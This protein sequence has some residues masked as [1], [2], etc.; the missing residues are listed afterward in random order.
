MINISST[1]L[2]LTFFLS[3]H[4]QQYPVMFKSRAYISPKYLKR[5]YICINNRMQYMTVYLC[6]ARIWTIGRG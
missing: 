5:A 3:R 6:C 4:F 1:Q 2:F